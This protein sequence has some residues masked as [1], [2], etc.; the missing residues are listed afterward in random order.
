MTLHQRLCLAKALKL[1]GQWCMAAL[2]LGIL[3][4]AELFACGALATAVAF[5]GWVWYR[6]E[7]G[8]YAQGY[9]DSHCERCG[10]LMLEMVNGIA[11]PSTTCR[12]CGRKHDL[13]VV[14]LA[15]RR[16]VPPALTV[17]Y[18]SGWQACGKARDDSL[19]HTPE[20]PDVPEW[21]VE[22]VKR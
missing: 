14:D 16:P 9:R 2:P 4:S 13:T 1:T 17:A 20:R 7:E 19:Y 21:R 10:A 3:H 8:Q 11:E 22:P 5:A 12:A 18:D 6:V 15:T